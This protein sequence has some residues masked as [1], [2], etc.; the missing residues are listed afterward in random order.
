M[1]QH[2]REHIFS[3]FLIDAKFNFR[4][5]KTNVREKKEY[6]KAL[7]KYWLH[8]DILGVSKNQTNFDNFTMQ[9]RMLPEQYNGDGV[10]RDINFKIPI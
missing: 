10:K 4:Q 3:W 9:V 2:K 8:L 1:S 6:A 7:H 5:V